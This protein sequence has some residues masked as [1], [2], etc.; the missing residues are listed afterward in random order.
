MLSE[1]KQISYIFNE[2]RLE[3]S[4]HVESRL[5]RHCV[6]FRPKLDIHAELRL[7]SNILIFSSSSFD[8]SQR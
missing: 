8:I 1:F 4:I 5:V 7:K 6:E 3:L 2:P